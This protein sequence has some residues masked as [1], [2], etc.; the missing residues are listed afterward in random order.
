MAGNIFTPAMM[1]EA[2][3][4][5]DGK[6]RSVYLELAY[7]C[8]FSGL[9]RLRQTDIAEIMHYS[10]KTVAKAFDTIEAKGLLQKV[11]HG[12]YKVLPLKTTEL[13]ASK[14]RPFSKDAIALRPEA[15]QA[16]S[17]E[18]DWK[19]ALKKKVAEWITEQDGVPKDGMVIG[20]DFI[21]EPEW[22]IEAVNN[23]ILAF[24]GV[25]DGMTYYKLNWKD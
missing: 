21:E 16:K 15:P 10:L 25:A 14:D 7:R 24:A 6:D 9:L 4:P 11:G 20:A 13:G 5:L 19:T 3:M 2:Q 8:E 1:P 18:P 22:V 23:D 12:R 17:T